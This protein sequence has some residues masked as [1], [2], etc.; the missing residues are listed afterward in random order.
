MSWVWL[1]GKMSR[2]ELMQKHPLEYEE[3]QSKLSEREPQ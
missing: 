3:L 2:E 1:T